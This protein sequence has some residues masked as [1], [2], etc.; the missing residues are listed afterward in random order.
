MSLVPVAEN[1]KTKRYYKYYE[2]GIASPTAQQ[3]AMIDASKGTLEECLEIEERNKMLEP[4]A[5]YPEKRGYYPT[6][7][8]GLLVAGNI[9]M[10]DVNAEM[11][12]WW[13]AWHG[14]EPFRYAIWDPEDHFGLEINEEGR[15]R[16]LDPS[17]PMAEKN[18]NATHTVQESIGGPPDEIVIMFKNPA[19]MG[20]DMSK[21]GVDGVDFLICA[22]ALL[23][24]MKMPVVMT[25]VAKKI[26]GVMTFQARFWVGYHII[27][28]EAKLLVPATKKIPEAECD[29]IAKGL[30][31][32]NIKEFT[33]LNRI[34]PQVYAEENGKW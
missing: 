2:Q 12:Y 26:N 32:H 8:G 22:N 33:N 13:W 3:L 30:L 7:D 27:D 1:A 14:L 24:P 15:K 4:E 34:L 9:P 23:G 25:E 6:K 16:A 19:E 11:L 20:F 29:G 21:V 18:W 28:G 10:P 17:I 31:A 5:T